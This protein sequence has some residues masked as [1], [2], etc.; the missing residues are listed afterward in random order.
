M[1]ASKSSRVQSGA[2]PSKGPA[3]RVAIVK[4]LTQVAVKA[5]GVKKSP[6]KSVG[7]KKM[8]KI[9]SIAKAPTPTAT[10]AFVLREAERVFGDAEKARRWLERPNPALDNRKPR[11]LLATPAGARAVRDELVKIDH[12]MLS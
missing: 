2:K 8:F 7:G 9:N 12:G 4:P 6:A 3:R 10:E 11:S 1:R 5:S